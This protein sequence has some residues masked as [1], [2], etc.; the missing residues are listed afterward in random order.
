MSYFP[1]SSFNKILEKI[2]HDRISTFV[3]IKD[4][5]Y[6]L[7]FGLQQIYSTLFSMIHLTE[8]I[9]EAHDPDKNDWEIFV[10]LQRVLDTVDH[11]ILLGKL[12][13]YDIRGAA[14]SW[15]ESHLED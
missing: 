15:R 6:P 4:I 9:K 1:L 10:D 13:Y 5:I 14:Y 12:K 7:Q 8:T 11:N 3:N 2:L